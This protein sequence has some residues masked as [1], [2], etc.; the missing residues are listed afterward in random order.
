MN[1]QMRIARR[2][3]LRW[4]IATMLYD[5]RTNFTA[6]D[7]LVSMLKQEFNVTRDELQGEIS[8]LE[9]SKFVAVERT[10]NDAYRAHL[11]LRWRGV[12]LVEGT[13]AAP[14]GIARPP[15]GHISTSAR[16]RVYMVRG[17]IL[18]ALDVGRSFPVPEGI[19]AEIVSDPHCQIGRDALRMELRYLASRQLIELDDNGDVWRAKL[20]PLG[21][22][23]SMGIEMCYPG[24]APRPDCSR[25]L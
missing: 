18:H 2:T 4:R 7:M 9:S 22:D 3:L 6:D 17:R 24:I 21:A 19:L 5:L 20:T 15:E 25:D 11:R 13:S 14:E 10:P 1:T 23:V 16:H 12:D 8:Y